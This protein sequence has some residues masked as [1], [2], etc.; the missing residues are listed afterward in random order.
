[1]YAELA[2]LL[3]NFVFEQARLLL[4]NYHFKNGVEMTTLHVPHLNMILQNTEITMIEL[5]KAF[6]AHNN[7]KDSKQSYQMGL[8]K[9]GR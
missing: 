9:N 5:S 3:M 4:N 8:F 7:Y 6:C 1:M 2:E